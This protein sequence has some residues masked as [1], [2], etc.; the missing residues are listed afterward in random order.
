MLLFAAAT[1]FW[2]CSTDPE[3]DNGVIPTP[4]D[5]EGDD[6][7][8]GD[9]E[10][11][12]DP[13]DDVVCDEGQVCV[14]GVCEYITDPGYSCAEPFDLGTLTEDGFFTMSVNPVGQPNVVETTCS[15][16]DESSQVVFQFEV[17]GPTRITFDTDRVDPDIPI[18]VMARELRA[19]SC[20]QAEAM[21][22]C[23]INPRT[24]EALP[25][26]E[27]YLIIESNEG[28]ELSGFVLEYEVEQLVC[29]PPGDWSCEGGERSLCYQGLEERVFDCAGECAG[30]E[31]CAGDRCSTAIEVTASQTFSGDFAA[32]ENT[33]DFSGSPTCTT[34]QTAGVATPGRDVVFA[35]PGLETG[36]TVKVDKGELGLA[37]IAVMSECSRSGM[38]C[39]AGDT[40]V[41]ELEWT[42]PADGSYF[43]V[44]SPRTAASGSFEFSIE[45]E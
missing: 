32:Y 30:S 36:Q 44:I 33:F 26:E 27:Y 13:C 29:F 37:V 6:D 8:D 18:P 14:D 20:R 5:L 12:P 16:S 22:W 19:G 40:Q 10:P 39:L 17:A 15:N 45:I 21:E 34:D 28:N 31:E 9:E 38:T 23:T 3:N 35:L 2:G 24:F 7:G 42:V 41:G 1:G 11:D 43:V 25:G 4:G